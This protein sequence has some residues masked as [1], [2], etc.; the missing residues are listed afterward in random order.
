MN[1]GKKVIS[2]SL[3]VQK[4]RMNPSNKDQCGE[5]Y[6]NG[7]IRN[8]EIQRDEGIFKQWT[9]RIFIDDSVPLHIQSK[10]KSMGA[11]LI[12]MTNVFIPNTNGKHYPG[13]FWRFLPMLDPNV[14]IFIVRDID[15]RINPRDE[16]AV[17]EWLQSDK[18][19]HVMRDHPHH[20]YK[21]LGGMWGHK[22][23]I[24]RLPIE[25]MIIGFLKQRKYEFNRM[26]DMTFLNNVYDY[27]Y[28][29]G[30]KHMILEHDQF[31]K[32]PYSIP[33]PTQEYDKCKGNY[34]KYIGE[35]YDKDDNAITKNRDVDLF[36][37]YKNKMVNKIHL[38]R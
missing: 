18:I 30:K 27:Y 5:M 25:A 21:I 35:M 22:C 36:K 37:N 20:Y 6:R 23:Y 3:W 11:E 7:A 1:N 31:F 34:Y 16:N 4:D 10:L 12:N 9:F 29:Y 15:S 2:M 14:N 28:D 33:F 26:D 13:M 32:F 8:M 38:F 19:L 24:H 17:N